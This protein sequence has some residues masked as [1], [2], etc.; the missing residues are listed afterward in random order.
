MPPFTVK[1]VHISVK[2]LAAKVT[3]YKAVHI[4]IRITTITGE[5]F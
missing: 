5:L 3:F 4:I 1:D 2:I